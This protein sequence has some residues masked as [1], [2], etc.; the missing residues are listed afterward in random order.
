MK[1]IALSKHLI[2]LDLVTYIE[3]N[4]F[5]GG[6]ETEIVIHFAVSGT[7]DNPSLL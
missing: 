3:H 4:V 7:S 2:N 5:D 1:F 6:L